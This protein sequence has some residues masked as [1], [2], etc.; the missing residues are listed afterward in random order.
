MYRNIF[1]K[2]DLLEKEILSFLSLKVS[3]AFVCT[4]NRGLFFI[5]AYNTYKGDKWQL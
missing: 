5:D 1:L 4:I 2:L 3:V